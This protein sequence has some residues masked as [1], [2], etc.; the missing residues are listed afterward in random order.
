[1]SALEASGREAEAVA[2]LQEAG[3]HMMAFYRAAPGFEARFAR[4]GWAV[5]TGEPHY[6][7]NW[8]AVLGGGSHGDKLLRE[9]VGVL[10]QRGVPG[11]VY[12]TDRAAT[13]LE[14]SC[15]DLGLWPPGPVPLMVRPAAPIADTETAPFEIGQVRDGATLRAMAEVVANAFDM[16]AEVAARCFGTDLL[17][18]YVECFVALRDGVVWSAAAASRFNASVYIDIMATDPRR[19]RQGAGRA[20]L[21]ALMREHQRRGAERFYL[22]ASDEGMGL[23]EQLGYQTIMEG[24]TRMVTPER[25][26]NFA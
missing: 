6:L 18:S 17:A 15:D 16:P 19:K 12:F 22:V 7:C 25:A 3:L 24:V 1:M 20:I 2:L 4:N 13:E 9:Y 21:N 23:Y 26:A 5:L 14:A 10:R 11:L 8:I